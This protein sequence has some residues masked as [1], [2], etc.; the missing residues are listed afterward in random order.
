[1]EKTHKK[2]FKII[3][4]TKFSVSSFS[5]P[6]NSD[7]AYQNGK[8]QEGQ[9]MKTLN[10]IFESK[11]LPY[12]AVNS[13]SKI[14]EMCRKS[15]W[16]SLIDS[17]D[18]D[19]YIYETD[20][21]RENICNMTP[22]LYIDVKVAYINKN[23]QFVSTITRKSYDNFAGRKNHYYWVFTEDGSYNIFIN[24]SNLKKIVD[25]ENPWNNSIYSNDK[26]RKFDFIK[27][28]WLMD[29]KHRF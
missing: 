16:S 23:K 27:G 11:K 5:S 20:S 17:I 12:I 19:I 18:G 22:I 10:D 8:T 14:A 26:N 4:T 1:M 7:E 9:I 28:E 24:S 3:T 29:N 21:K 2:L 6:K 13:A 25:A 15:E